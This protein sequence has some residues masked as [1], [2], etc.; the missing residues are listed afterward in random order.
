ML[1]DAQEVNRTKVKKWISSQLVPALKEW[2]STREAGEPTDIAPVRTGGI[3]PLGKTLKFKHVW[4]YNTDFASIDAL[5][6]K[7]SQ[8]PVELS[9]TVRLEV[10]AQ[11][12][13][14]HI[15]FTVEG[16]SKYSIIEPDILNWNKE[17]IKRDLENKMFGVNKTQ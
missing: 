6:R 7:S 1:Q 10:P 5:K 13:I 16:E 3:C 4:P 14:G 11:G 15:E 8:E 17:Q 2:A 12:V 9:Y